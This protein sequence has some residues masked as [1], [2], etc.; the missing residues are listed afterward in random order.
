MNLP[1]KHVIIVTLKDPILATNFAKKDEKDS[2]EKE[3]IMKYHYK[4]NKSKILV[5]FIQG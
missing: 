3:S 1:D 2:K 4:Y 5:I